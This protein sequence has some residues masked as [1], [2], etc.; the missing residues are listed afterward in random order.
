MRPIFFLLAVAGLFWGCRQ[1]ELPSR[2]PGSGADAKAAVWVYLNEQRGKTIL[3]GQMDLTWAPSVDMA[4]RVRRTTGK[5]PALM[6]YDLM[7]FT[8]RGARTADADGQISEAAAWWNRGGLVTFCWH[9]RDPSGASDSFYSNGVRIPL[10]AGEFDPTAPVG[11]AMVADMDFV[12]GQLAALR[13]AGVPVLWRPLHE[14][15]GSG[16]P[17]GSGAWFW[18]GQSGA[19]AYKA[20]YRFMHRRFTEVHGLDNLIWVWNGQG[21]DWYPG[22]DVADLAGQD[23]YEKSHRSQ[24]GWYDTLGRWS[25][26]KLAALTEVGAIPDPDLLAAEGAAFS[27]FLVWNDNP[28]VNLAQAANNFWSGSGSS[29]EDAVQYPWNTPTFEKRVY[30][31]PRVIT[32]DELSF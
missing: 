2:E 19:A 32:L 16:S 31:H 27:W 18:W 14:A 29:V 17:D 10:K 26:G 11:A 30:S 20:L 1:A 3:A 25:G 4:A 13:D 8:N 7:N 21:Q 12:A 23:V 9:W 15:G 24:K 5:E 22:S 6:G 28:T